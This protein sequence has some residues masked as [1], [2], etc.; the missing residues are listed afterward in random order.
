MKDREYRT[1]KDEVP[2]WFEEFKKLNVLL[3]KLNYSMF[4]LSKAYEEVILGENNNSD[5]EIHKEISRL[6]NEKKISCR[7]ILFFWKLKY[8]SYYEMCYSLIEKLHNINNDFWRKLL[9]FMKW[10][11]KKLELVINWNNWSTKTFKFDDKMN[12]EEIFNLLAI[13]L[14]IYESLKNQ[15]NKT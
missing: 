14:D 1:F 2:Q 7:K 10:I 15:K 4:L 3:E 9:L 12:H 13:I 6:I 5:N 11:E 8:L